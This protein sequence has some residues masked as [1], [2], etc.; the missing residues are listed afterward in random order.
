MNGR[1]LLLVAIA[2]ISL[3]HTADAQRRRSSSSVRVDT[4][5]TLAKNGT[6]SVT[7]RS[8]DVVVTGW[9]RDQVQIRGSTEYGEIR[10]QSSGSRIDIGNLRSEEDGRIE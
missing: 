3:A 5:L 9:S 2:A 4:T 7:A 1:G 8:G 6:V 10:V